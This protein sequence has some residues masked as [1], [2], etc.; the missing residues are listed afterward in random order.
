MIRVSNVGMTTS[1]NFR[2]QNHKL[3]LVEVEGSHTMQD[4]YDSL[5]IHVGQSVAFLV[6]LNAD[7]KDY[8]IVA[9]SRFVR[10]TLTASAILHYDGSVTKVTG[11]LPAP[12]TGQYHWSMEQARSLR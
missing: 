7:V 10:P 1:I 11:N 2:I 12:P 6:T 4:L 8:Y 9:S 3:K 5:D